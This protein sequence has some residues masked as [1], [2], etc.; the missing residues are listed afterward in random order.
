MSAQNATTEKIDLVELNE[1]I[2]S[3]KDR[4]WMGRHMTKGE[5]KIYKKTINKMIKSYNDTIGK[6]VHWPLY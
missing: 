5:K 1:Q 3:A 2:I 4:Y 6:E